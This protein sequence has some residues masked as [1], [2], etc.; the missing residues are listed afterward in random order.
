MINMWLYVEQLFN[1][2]NLYLD[3][4]GVMTSLFLCETAALLTAAHTAPPV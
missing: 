4:V 1:S 2:L 3:P